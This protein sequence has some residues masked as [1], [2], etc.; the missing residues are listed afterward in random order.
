MKK[1]LLLGLLFVPTLA[2]AQVDATHYNLVING[3]ASSRY[4]FPAASLTCNLATL[5]GTDTALNPRY[6]VW[7]D[8]LV[9][10]R[11]CSHDTGAN[12]GPLFALPI[13]DY[14]AFIEP[15]VRTPS[16]ASVLGPPSNI[17]SFSR[18]VPPAA[19]TGLRVRGA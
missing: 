9:A 13:G 14:T 5:P 10:G 17:A 8:P 16:G 15:E 12:T 2:E 6:V 1:L 7:N 4:N 3:A 19:R 11:Y 18:L